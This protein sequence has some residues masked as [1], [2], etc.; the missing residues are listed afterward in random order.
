MSSKADAT[1]RS[2]R[3]AM[4]DGFVRQRTGTLTCSVVGRPE[5]FFLLSGQLYLSGTNPCRY[6][7][8]RVLTAP[9][10]ADDPRFDPR[11]YLERE[12]AGIVRELTSTLASWNVDEVVLREVLENVPDNI[13]GPAPTAALV[14]D[15]ATHNSDSEELFRRLGGEEASY[16]TFP[17]HRMRR[18]VPYLRADELGL[19]ER[20]KKRAAVGQLIEETVDGADSI[21]PLARLVAVGLVEAVG[22][23]AELPTSE[24]EDVLTGMSDRIAAD[25]DA[26]PLD[27]EPRLH[28]VQ[29]ETMLA[30]YGRLSY[31]EL[32]GVGGNTPQE[33]VDEAFMGLARLAHPRHAS[34]LDLEDSREHLER[35]LVRLTEAYLAL[36]APQE[37]EGSEDAD[38]DPASPDRTSPDR[39]DVESESPERRAEREEVADQSYRAALDCIEVDD[40]YYAIQLLER[41]TLANPRAEYYSL[42]GLCQ[43][44]N[45]KW[46]HMAVDS[47]ER[48]CALSPEDEV[49]REYLS[50]AQ[51]EHREY[52]DSVE[53]ASAPQEGPDPPAQLRKAWVPA[54]LVEPAEPIASVE[55]A[56]RE[57]PPEKLEPADGE[58]ADGEEPPG[59][60]ESTDH[61]EPGESQETSRLRRLVS[62]LWPS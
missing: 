53:A 26:H 36:S 15:L 52:L 22:E 25:L 5:V 37:E 60:D 30:S 56:V 32:L 61:E 59:H 11:V 47:L 8:E 62:K 20:L 7:L 3:D 43:R 9:P 46:L 23:S 29:V 44:K 16:R 57:E 14:M 18:R 13:V 40:Y 6:R 50:E 38:G 19:L 1:F 49:L 58:P 12:L 21:R 17:D 45:P 48:A 24:P 10:D 42:L 31:Y 35:L 34:T 33:E 54:K 27:L 55:A 4:H 2:L 41:A 28:R 39:P 51:K